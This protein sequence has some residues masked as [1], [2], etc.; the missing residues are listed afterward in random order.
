MAVVLVVAV[1]AVVELMLL[2]KLASEELVLVVTSDI[3]IDSK[4]KGQWMHSSRAIVRAPLTI[5]KVLYG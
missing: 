5:Q 3:W 4:C 1:A 2:V